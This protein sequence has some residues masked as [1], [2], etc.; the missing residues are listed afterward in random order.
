VWALDLSIQG[1]KSMAMKLVKKTA[2]YSI[3]RRGDER[4]AVKDANNRP[5]NGDEKARI[6]VAEELIKETVSAKPAV[7]EAPE[8]EAVAEEAAVEEESPAEEAPAEEAPAEETPAE[9][10]PAEETPAEETP[11]EDAA[12]KEGK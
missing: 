4:Y 3:Y 10:T 9:E 1:E 6:L 11:A 7:E 12:E 5:V 8:T 2:E